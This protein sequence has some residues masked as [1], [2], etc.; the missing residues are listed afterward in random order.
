MDTTTIVFL[1]SV[2]LALGLATGWI[3]YRSDFCIAGM[4]RDLF[5]FGRTDM[6]RSLLLLVVVSTVLFEIARL[7]GLL[8]LYPFPLLYAPTAANLAGG[9]LFGLG[10]VLAGGCVV[11]TLYKLGAG[12]FPSLVT[13]GGL[14]VG[15]A[16]YAEIH[17]AWKAF[18]GR[19]TFFAGRITVPQ[20]L[21]V[22]PTVPLL[23]AAAAGGFLVFRWARD[24][25]F[26]RASPVEGYLQP[27]KAALALAVIGLLSWTLVGMPLG[28]TS[29]YA[30]IAGY[31]E[32]LFFGKHVLANAYFQ[33]VPLDCTQ[34]VTGARIRGGGGPRFDAIAAIQFPLVAGIVL[35]SAAAA[36]SVGE[37][38]M[39]FQAP[40]RQLASALAGG[41]LMGLA[42]RMA[43][44]C[45]VWHLLGG[46][47]ILAASSIL[48]LAGLLPG[49]WAGS[50]LFTSFVVRKA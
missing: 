45:N 5:L 14:L 47:P 15:S 25:R 19:T 29:S 9:F 41:I 12:S 32:S 6:L 13:F 33:A 36:R 20:I 44:T 31:L 42:S 2:S 8:P 27:W 10:M 3:M 17:P 30:K 16:L 11:G 23:L 37:L 4:F 34:P 48:F 1:M 26:H 24:G 43:P 22:G 18:I 38:R 7:A 35:G 21:G 39:R 28:I 49:A 40:G 50:I 46:I